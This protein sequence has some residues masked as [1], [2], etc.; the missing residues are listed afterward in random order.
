[1]HDQRITVQKRLASIGL[2]KSFP[3]ELW[4]QQVELTSPSAVEHAVMR[5]V[6]RDEDPAYARGDRK[7]GLIF[8]A[9]ASK[10]PGRHDIVL[11]LFEIR[12]ERCRD[13]LVQVEVGQV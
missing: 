11:I 4:V 12:Y 8:R 5:R 3:A 13:V 9:F 1:L 7:F 2:S 6:M 10:E